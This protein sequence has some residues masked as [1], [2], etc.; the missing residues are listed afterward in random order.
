MSGSK[1]KHIHKKKKFS[2]DL[3]YLY[4]I[5]HLLKIHEQGGAEVD[6]EADNKTNEERF[7]KRGKHCMTKF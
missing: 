1:V 3:F 6:W 7:R 4:P 5:K 2:P